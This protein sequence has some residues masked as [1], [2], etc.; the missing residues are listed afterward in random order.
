MK[1]Y[2][3]TVPV[4]AARGRQSWIVKAKDEEDAIKFVTIGVGEFSSEEIEVTDLNFNNATAEE[5]S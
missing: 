4:K 3:V 1:E 2:I 5:N